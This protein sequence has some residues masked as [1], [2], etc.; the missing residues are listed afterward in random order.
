MTSTD[1]LRPPTASRALA[2]ALLRARAL[3]A[4]STECQRFERLKM[5]GT[6]SANFH[7]GQRS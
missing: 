5:I 6:Q 7:Q 3:A 1:R 2:T 4:C